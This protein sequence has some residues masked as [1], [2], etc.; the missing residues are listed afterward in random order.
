MEPNKDREY[1]ELAS[2]I[3]HWEQMRWVCMT[4]FVA[5]MFVAAGAL[6]SVDFRLDHF[7]LR[8]VQVGALLMVTI[9][10]VQDER[11]VAYWDSART[12]AREVEKELGIEVFSRAPKRGLFSAGTAVRC[13]YLLFMSFWVIQMFR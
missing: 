13:L 1:S 6:F 12:R 8:L 7:E 2:N 9:F 10:W 4:V 11:I 5:L 3:R